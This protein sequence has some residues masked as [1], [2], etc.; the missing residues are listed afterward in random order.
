MRCSEVMARDVVTV[1]PSS[2][3]AEA[4]RL[5]RDHDV[6]FLPV[7]E[8]GGPVVGVLTDR[9]VTL[10]VCAEGLRAREVPV[11]EVMSAELTAV[12]P[13]DTVQL[14]EEMMAMYHR[15]R[16]LV[17]DRDRGLMGVVSLADV[18]IVDSGPR[19]GETLRR[20]SVRPKNPGVPST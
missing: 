16:V 17:L 14:A 11:S 4:A 3:V 1:R 13:E 19:P 5:M 6:G 8:D 9:D 20:L 12:G 2:S 7:R 18:A 10:R 15:A